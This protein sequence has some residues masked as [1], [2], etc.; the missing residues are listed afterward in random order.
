MNNTKQGSS[1][2]TYIDYHSNSK[3]P[4]KGKFSDFAIEH[5]LNETCQM[6]WETAIPLT[7]CQYTPCTI[8]T[9]CARLRKLVLVSIGYHVSIHESVPNDTN[10]WQAA[11]E[12]ANDE[13]S[14]SATDH[15]FVHYPVMRVLLEVEGGLNARYSQETVVQQ[16]SVTVHI[17]IN[18]KGPT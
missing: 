10:L 7:A 12:F 5:S 3:T 8:I 15:P 11:F 14:K 1:H 9:T 13:T 17:H 18:L 16:S 2:S 4:D 6:I